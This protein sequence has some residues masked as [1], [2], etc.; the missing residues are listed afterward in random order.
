ML[1]LLPADS[2]SGIASAAEDILA[3][4]PPLPETAEAS[5]KMPSLFELVVHEK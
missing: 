1:G 3:K 2:P 5:M 4:V